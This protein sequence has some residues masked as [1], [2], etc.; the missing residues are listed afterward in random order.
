MADIPID[1]N[2]IVRFL[3]EDPETIDVKFR[4]I[5]SFFTKLESGKLSVHLP[6]LVLFQTYFVLTSYYGVPSPEAAEKLATLL[7]LPGIKMHHKEIVSDCLKRLQQKKQDI[8][9]AY[10]LAW[11]ENKGLPGV[12]SFDKGIATETVDVLPVR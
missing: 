2:V 12:Y 7:M 3:V 11:A 8:V 4:G 9:D 10:L 6:E 1:T 5:Y